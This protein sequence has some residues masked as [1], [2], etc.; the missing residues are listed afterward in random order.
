MNVFRLQIGCTALFTVATLLGGVSC[1]HIPA[2]IRGHIL[3]RS[4]LTERER[5]FG[6][7]P[8]RDR[9]VVY[10][11]GVIIPEG[12]AE[13]IRKSG[14]D[15][16]SW[17]ID[18]DAAGVRD[19]SAGRI[20]FITGRCVGRVLQ[21]QR[22]GSDLKLTLGPVELTDLFEKLDLVVTQEPIDLSKALQ[23]PPPE[24]PSKPYEVPQD[25]DEWSANRGH[26]IV[27]PAAL[28]SDSRA[29]FVPISVNTNQ[30]ESRK[31]DDANGV[32]MQLYGDG[33]GLRA[34][35]QVQLRIAKP[36]LDAHIS[37][38]A[39]K[40]DASVLFHNAA[41]IRISFESAVNEQFPGKLRWYSPA[42]QLS[43]PISGPVP[44]S[45]DIRQDIF[46]DAVFVSRVSSF[47][48]SGQYDFNADIGFTLHDGKFDVV[49]PKGIS[50][51]QELMSSYNGISIA[52]RELALRHGV[53]FTAGLGGAGFTIGPQVILGTRVEAV[54]GSDVG[55]VDCRGAFLTLG[56]KGGVGWTIPRVI[57]D[58]INAIL[59]IIHVTP[60]PDHKGT[61]SDWKYFI[62][63]RIQTG[64]GLCRAATT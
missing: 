34:L 50:V 20:V 39:G 59:S 4:E 38:N 29:G 54:K 64:N 51:K 46:L 9:S 22:E 60:V 18:A 37:I 24:L 5:K 43:F 40:V 45:I 47:S 1:R 52:P 12:G 62:N 6:R 56:V 41:G 15:G 21:V 19:V 31:L 7:A 33:K 11:R 44:F 58:V 57:A 13:I 17:T 32:G 23:Y 28:Q 26:S 53:T 48:G 36:T 3:S 61:Y 16:I 30:K 14:A 10:R 2:P 49:G 27:R 42:G 63:R 25:F 55:L 8:K 35:A